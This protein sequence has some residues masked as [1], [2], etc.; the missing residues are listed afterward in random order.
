VQ[1][2]DV[3]KKQHWIEGL[4]NAVVVKDNIEA[5]SGNFIGLDC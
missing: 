2:G 5:W 1:N 3:S 4:R